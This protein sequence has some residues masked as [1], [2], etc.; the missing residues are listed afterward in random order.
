MTL[1]KIVETRVKL[2]ES[3]LSS[4]ICSL[5]YTN[6]IEF[7]CTLDPQIHLYPP[8]SGPNISC[9]YPCN[10]A[11]TQ[12]REPTDLVRQISFI[13]VVPPDSSILQILFIY[14]DFLKLILHLL[15]L[16]STDGFPQVAHDEFFSG[17]NQFWRTRVQ[18]RC[19]HFRIHP[20][21]FPK[22]L[23]IFFKVALQDCFFHSRTAYGKPVLF[24]TYSFAS[25]RIFRTFQ[26]HTNPYRKY[27]NDFFENFLIVEYL[28]D[29]RPPACSWSQ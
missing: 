24:C 12:S 8:H 6:W 11:L 4:S 5:L 10:L 15:Q 28:H 20:I 22:F 26:Q 19:L 9:L 2:F 7:S 14:L 13:N 16:H 1:Q 18:Q 23:C 25:D 17:C 29:A 27:V 3:Y 21:S